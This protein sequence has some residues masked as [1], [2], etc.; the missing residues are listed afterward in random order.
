MESLEVDLS[1]VLL[2][3]I[4]AISSTTPEFSHIDVRCLTVCI[5]SGRE[6][7]GGLCGK[8]VP[9]RFQDGHE[10]VRHEGRIYAMPRILRDGIPQLYLIYFYLPRFFNRDARD[11][12]RII[13]HELYHISPLYNG[14][15]RRMGKHKAAHGHSRAAFDSN[16]QAAS[17][18]FYAQIENSP[19]MNFLMLDSAGIARNFSRVRAARMRVPHPQIVDPMKPDILQ[20]EFSVRQFSL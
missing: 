3:L 6:G 19:Y 12:L 11:K 9:L 13:F 10:Q 15:I 20:R 16:F 5:A 2:Y 7:S 14:D 1:E 8:L 18:R 4:H 17:D